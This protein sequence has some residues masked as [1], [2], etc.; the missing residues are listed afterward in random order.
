MAGESARRR[1][2]PPGRSATA[3]RL[4]DRENRKRGFKNG[5]PR[6]RQPW[7]TTMNSRRSFLTVAAAVAATA[8]GVP[9]ARGQVRQ[10]T[11]DV[12]KIGASGGG[13]VSD[14]RPIRRALEMA[15]EHR[16]GATIYF[17][18]GDYYL[19]A[20]EEGDLLVLQNLQNI[21]F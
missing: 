21:R 19:G 2:R 11:I 3:E 20:V 6:T 1:S 17:P 10:P 4:G 9:R 12:K 13:K 14:L 5:F 15:A 16:A 7:C 18:P 8:A